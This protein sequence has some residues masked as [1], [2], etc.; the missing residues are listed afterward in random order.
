MRPRPVL[1]TMLLATAVA[2]APLLFTTPASAEDDPPPPLSPREALASIRVKPG[3]TVE[4]VASEPLIVDP[5]AID[6]GPD[7]R[8][9]V[10]EMH[11]YPMGLDGKYS[12]GGRI[13][14]LED[15][16]NDGRYD[17][18]TVFLD[19]LPFPTGVKAWRQGAL[20]CAAPQVIYAEDTDGDGKAD[21][22]EVVLEGFGADNYQARVNSL[23][24]GLD[25]WLY[26][27]SGLRGGRITMIASGKVVDI[28]TR[29][30]RIRMD[31]GIL[32]PASG[33][34]Q[35][36]R[37]RD[38]WNN[39]FG[40]TNSSL[41]QHYPLPDHDAARNPHV[42]PPGPYV[43][44]PRD[45]DNAR[46]YPASRTLARYNDIHAANHVTSACSPAIYRDELLGPEYQRQRLHVRA[47]PQPRHPTGARARRRHLRRPPCPG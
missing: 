10:C 17:K 7:G 9:W 24:L 41:L 23:Y 32:E 39:H 34:T 16:D 26:G 4:L 3:F 5:V 21:R 27:A 33:R 20:I 22:R 37:T 2:T 25:N 44:V 13:K 8:L 11:D 18:A 19:G 38:D 6:F 30:F 31:E 36:G 28:G 45:A 12:P 1:R 14:T 40:N 47:G 29:D 46:V 43:F 35:H 42:V 15:T